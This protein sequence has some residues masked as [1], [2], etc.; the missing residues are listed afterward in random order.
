VRGF[1]A[2]QQPF[3]PRYVRLVDHVATNG[4]HTSLRIGGKGRND[5]LGDGYLL[6]I[7]VNTS[8]MMAT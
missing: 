8:L 4:D 2:R 6:G 1:G 3:G 5:L 7:G